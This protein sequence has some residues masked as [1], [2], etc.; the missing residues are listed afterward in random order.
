M[1]GDHQLVVVY[2]A[3]GDLNRVFDTGYSEVQIQSAFRR[4]LERFGRQANVRTMG[5][6][7]HYDRS[8]GGQ[9]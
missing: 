8:V 4:C 3:F 2:D 9:R 7:E 5:A 6:K 1:A